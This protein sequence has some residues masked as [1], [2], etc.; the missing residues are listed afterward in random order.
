MK[1]I[2]LIN[3]LAGALTMSAITPLPEVGRLSI[4]AT[5]HITMVKR[6]VQASGV[7]KSLPAKAMKA[8][9][10]KAHQG[11]D[12]AFAA[13]T[14]KATA[15]DGLTFYESFEG[16]DGQSL[17]WLPAGWR[18]E[19]RG[20]ADLEDVN[21]WGAYNP[22]LGYGVPASPD[23]QM[24]MALIYCDDKHQQDEW[25]YTPSFTPK[26]NE[27]LSFQVFSDP[28][29]FFDLS[30]FD[31]DQYEFISREKKWNFE[32]WLKVGD[33]EFFKAWDW[34]DNFADLETLDLVYL[35]QIY[36]KYAVDLSAY[37]GKEV[38]AAFRYYGS[39]AQTLTID[40]VRVGLPTLEGVYY[41][42]PLETLYWGIGSLPGFDYIT[43][44]VAQYPTHQPI[45]FSNASD[46][47]ADF[48]WSYHDWE[49]KGME[50]SADEH[51]T[52]TYYPD[53][54]TDFTRRNNLYAFPTLIASRPGV[55]DGEFK[56]ACEYLQAGGKCELDAGEA[57]WEGSLMPFEINTE[58]W[59]VLVE[60]DDAIGAVVPVFGYTSDGNC[61]RYWLN[62][63][64]NGEPAQ[65]GDYVNL[66]AVM[67]FI[68]PTERALVVNG[69]NAF[70]L[71]QVKNGAKFD[72]QIL[73]LSELGVPDYEDPVAQATCT[74]DKF[75][76][77]EFGTNEIL[78]IPFRFT[79]PAV[80]ST[81]APAY[82]VRLSGFHDPENVTYFAPIMSEQPHPDYLCFGW[83]EK[84]MQ[85]EGNERLG[86]LSP[87]AY[88]EGPHGPC[89]NAFGLGLLAEYP[90]LDTE[91]TGIELP[92]DGTP[93][94]VNLGSYYDGAMLSVE[95][96]AGVTA[97]IVGRYDACQLTL[98]HNEADIVAK[99]DVKIT[100]PGV[101]LTIPLK[102]VMGA[103]VIE[104]PIE[105]TSEAYTIDG[106][107]IDITTAP[108]G[109][110]IKG[111][112]KVLRR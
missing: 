13:R 58:D 24:C 88:S 99:G 70:A 53:Y 66:T 96:P 42:N 64:L 100:G 103:D 74:G 72:I 63:S 78:T 27:E 34:L 112:T 9:A 33:G 25:L 73:A 68:Y 102:E 2:L 11:I 54:S 67:N 109:F 19:S 26:E 44:P 57:V 91:V 97:S 56:H 89:F 81:E 82:V 98:S 94:K 16:F 52:L 7:L 31:W 101:S 35:D 93:V 43:T 6:P 10:L 84:N 92:D 39:D 40:D 55:S 1:R 49:T 71:G 60:V 12:P 95:A 76:R 75:I 46:C 18:A 79:T 110:Y 17:Q 104:L 107:K 87:A 48:L 14:R 20:S 37:A 3:L 85:I 8:K 47:K 50:E 23:G 45:T 38:T 32:V 30:K 62:Y 86:S 29:W 69:V 22:A 111:R 108:A 36:R 51:L 105:E 5:S 106:R 80:L 77:E 90:W 21:K 15:V 28:F 65:E 4:D 41:T 61:D 59:M 83:A